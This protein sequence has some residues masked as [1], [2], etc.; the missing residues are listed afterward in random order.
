M[1]RHEQLRER[2]EDAVFALMMDEIATARGKEAEE[3]N[4]RLQNDPAAAVPED[5]D[6]RCLKTI[7]RHQAKDKARSAGR[8]TV[9]TFKRV[10]MAAGI[11]AIL[12][13]TAFA[14]SETV[15]V[16]TMNLVVRV[17]ETHTDYNFNGTGLAEWMEWTP[18]QLA[19]G[20]L[21]DDMK[22]REQY[23]SIQETDYRYYGNVHNDG[24]RTLRVKCERADG[25]GTNFDTED[26]Q[27]E[28][29]TVQGESAMLVTKQLP[30]GKWDIQLIWTTDDNGLLLNVCG[31]NVSREEILRAA[32]ALRY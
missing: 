18:P 9:K 26:A 1:T 5:V 2:Y 14:T 20:W 16:N 21:P 23:I 17:F 22:L 10:V 32:N 30:E 13:T 27:I 6:K 28:T 4:V 24:I 31:E 8:F 15:R 19:V 29:I 3:E 12:F 25:Q 11:A 7:R